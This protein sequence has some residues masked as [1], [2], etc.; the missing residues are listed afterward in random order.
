MTVMAL[1]SITV[2]EDGWN[3]YISPD[4]EIACDLAFSVKVNKPRS[5]RRPPFVSDARIGVLP[6]LYS[7]NPDRELHPMG[8]GTYQSCYPYR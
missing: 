3:L 2:W 4:D 5:T 1:H 6:F 8:K 7:G